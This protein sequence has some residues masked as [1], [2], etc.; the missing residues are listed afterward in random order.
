MNMLGGKTKL[1]AVLIAIGMTMY[2]TVDICPVASWIPWIKWIGTMIGG[3]GTA[4]GIVGIGNKVER[5][6]AA[7]EQGQV[8]Q[9]PVPQSEIKPLIADEVRKVIEEMRKE[10]A[11]KKT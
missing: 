6:A 10:R 3:V 4:L 5:A 7:V 11:A 1:G 8:P 9:M 2:S